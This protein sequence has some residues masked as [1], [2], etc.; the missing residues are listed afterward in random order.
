MPIREKIDSLKLHNLEIITETW[1]DD[2][3]DVLHSMSDE[4]AVTYEGYITKTLIPYEGVDI[5]TTD[6]HLRKIFSDDGFFGK[7]NIESGD[8]YLDLLDAK[9]AKIEELQSSYI[10]ASYVTVYDAI[11]SKIV[12]SQI[13][14]SSACYASY[15]DFYNLHVT[16]LS[17]GDI[18]F[19]YGWRLRE[20]YEGLYLINQRTGKKYRFVLEELN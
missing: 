7:I 5:G 13:I 3:I 12:D 2:L 18:E 4:S 8:A 6:R 20:D 16:Y 11:S 19:E 9:Y 14:R 1:Y 17:V 10:Y 15:G